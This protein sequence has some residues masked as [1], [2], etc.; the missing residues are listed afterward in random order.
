MEYDV[1]IMDAEQGS[2]FYING[3]S[4]R[5][6]FVSYNLKGLDLLLP[7]FSSADDWE[8]LRDW[9]LVFLSFHQA[10]LI[11]ENDLVDDVELFFNPDKINQV[12]HFFA[13][14]LHRHMNNDDTFHFRSIHREFYAGTKIFERIR[15]QVESEHLSYFYELVRKSQYT[16]LNAANSVVE[17]INENLS[18][19]F[20]FISNEGS[21]VLQ[22][23][24]MIKIRENANDEFFI[25]YSSIDKLL[26]HGWLYL[27]EKQIYIPEMSKE[28]WK[29]FCAGA[30]E[31]SINTELFSRYVE[32]EDE[33]G[34]E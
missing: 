22:P 8:F 34:E 25:S 29:N 6:L 15:E 27:D 23:A 16:T 31:M 5:P 32:G 24:D 20:S 26:R 7:P 33:E 1:Q 19:T 17:K 30:R 11:A 4:T 21:I 12:Q 2:I 3:T 13:T 9:L 28:E 14:E 10:I 18:T